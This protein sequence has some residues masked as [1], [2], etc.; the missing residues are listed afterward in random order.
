MESNLIAPIRVTNLPEVIVDR[1]R[2]AIITNELKPGERLTE[3]TLSTQLG[4][5]RSP[6][7]EALQILKSEGLVVEQHNHSCLVWTPTVSDVD[8]IFSLR[9]M[10]ETL[11][12]EWLIRNITDEDINILEAMIVE[13]RRAYESEDVF[14]MI[15][16]DKHFHE[17]ICN[18][19]KHSRLNDLWGQIMWQWEVLVYRRARNNPELILPTAL[20]DHASIVEALKSRNL[21]RISELHRSI[22][23]N[24]AANVKEVLKQ[25][26]G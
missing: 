12:C 22:N 11:A 15:E 6:V 14:T 1:L 19:S 18:R 16:L 17:Y 23:I 9:A 5:S 13:Q 4:V 10:V 7:R 24:V 20:V 2:K 26:P 25:N 3:V 8:E 21:A